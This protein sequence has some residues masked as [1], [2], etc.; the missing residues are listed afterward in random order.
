MH[1]RILGFVEKDYY[2]SHKDSHDWE[3]YFED[4]PSFADYISDDSDLDEDFEWLVQ[5]L[6][7]DTDSSLLDVDMNEHTIKFKPG[8]KEAYFKPKFDKLVKQII[9]NEDFFDQFCGTSKNSRLDMYDFKKLID[10]EFGFYIADEHSC[11]ETLDTFV[12]SI[13]YDKTYLCFDSLDYH[14]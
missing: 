10:E 3:L 6:V 1:S 13:N 4:T 5:A 9:G 11:W 8:F 14:Y 7:H 12:R 2:D